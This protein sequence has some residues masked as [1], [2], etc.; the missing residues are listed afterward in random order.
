M[1]SVVKN[2]YFKTCQRF[3]KLSKIY[4]FHS[5]ENSYYPADLAF[6]MNWAD[7]GNKFDLSTWV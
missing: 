3:L 7:A 1:G 6:E 2:V 5:V 4:T